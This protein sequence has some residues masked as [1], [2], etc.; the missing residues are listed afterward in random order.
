MLMNWPGL[1]ALI[2][3]QLKPRVYKHENEVVHSIPGPCQRILT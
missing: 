3:D 1:K 2:K